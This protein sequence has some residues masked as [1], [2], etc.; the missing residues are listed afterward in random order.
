MAPRREPPK[1]VWE[2][3]LI[4][5]PLDVQYRASLQSNVAGVLVDNGSSWN[6][7]AFPEPSFHPPVLK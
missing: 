6:S 2:R 7:E 4:P 1:K 5:W 3:R